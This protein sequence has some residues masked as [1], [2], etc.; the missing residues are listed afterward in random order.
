MKYTEEV[1]KGSCGLDDFWSVIYL[2]DA[3]RKSRVNET[4][5]LMAWVGSELRFLYVVSK[6]GVPHFS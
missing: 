3:R 1:H 4:Y 2:V 6:L 5:F